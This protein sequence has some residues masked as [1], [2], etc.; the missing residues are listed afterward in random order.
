MMLALRVN[1]RQKYSGSVFW[2]AEVAEG[3]IEGHNKLMW[4]YFVDD[5]IF[6][7]MY[8]WQ[9]FKIRLKLFETICQCVM[10]FDTFFEQKEECRRK[11]WP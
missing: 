5:P 4:S 2:T 11:A 3:R 6:T 10:K 7:E 8:F 9:F 1:K